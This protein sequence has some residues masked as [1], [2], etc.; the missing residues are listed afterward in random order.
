MRTIRTIIG[1]RLVIA[2]VEAMPDFEV[3]E[4]HRT[5]AWNNV[6]VEIQKEIRETIGQFCFDNF[7][8]LVSEKGRGFLSNVS[9]V[10]DNIQEVG[11]EN[12]VITISLS[13]TETSKHEGE[14][15]ARVDVQ[16]IIMRNGNCT[17]SAE[18]A[19]DS[20]VNLFAPRPRRPRTHVFVNDYGV[21][22]E[23]F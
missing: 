22:D 17:F 20:A 11:V 4:P 8:A 13:P 16:S 7:S 5:F 2:S 14:T 10:I 1:S 6:S 18:S 21:S 19:L 23:V 9:D 15:L 12:G 3:P